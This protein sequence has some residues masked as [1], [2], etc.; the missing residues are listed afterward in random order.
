MKLLVLT[1]KVDTNDPILGFFHRWILEFAKHY[2]SV[3]VICLGSGEYDFPSNVKIYSLGKEGGQSR[4]KYLFRFYKYIWRER[5]NY[6]QVFVHMNSEYVVL[7]GFLWRFWGKKIMLWN[8]HAYGNLATWLAL[9]LSH[10]SFYTSP[11]SFNALQ[12]RQKGRQMPVG[13]DPELFRRDED[14]KRKENSLL[15]LGRISP[16]KNLNLLIEA[17]KLLDQEGINFVLNIVGDVA[18]KDIGYF[19]KMKI[20]ATDLENKGKVKFFSSVPNSLVPKIYNENEI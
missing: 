13:I 14:A 10:R 4:L 12:S 16:V 3:V 11:F 15:F 5:K 9:K 2:E 8:N 1:Q 19:E 20:M 6:D 17:V 7:G 18:S